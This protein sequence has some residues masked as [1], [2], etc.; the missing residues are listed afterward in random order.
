M[1][2]RILPLMWPSMFQ[3]GNFFY[4]TGVYLYLTQYTIEKRVASF[5]Y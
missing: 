4:D 2:T 5:L 1:K 3:M